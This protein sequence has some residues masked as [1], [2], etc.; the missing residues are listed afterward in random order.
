MNAYFVSER[1]LDFIKH[2][3][4]ERRNPVGTFRASFKSPMP[5]RSRLRLDYRLKE[6]IFILSNIRIL[7]EPDPALLAQRP[8]VSALIAH[9]IVQPAAEQ[10][11]IPSVW[12]HWRW[13]ALSSNG[14]AKGEGSIRDRTQEAQPAPRASS[15]AFF[16]KTRRWDPIFSCVR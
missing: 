13:T 3:D 7:P 6:K 8:Q 12:R 14:L 9:R 5:E 10:H 15:P 16:T 11:Q 1:K 2:L 4:V